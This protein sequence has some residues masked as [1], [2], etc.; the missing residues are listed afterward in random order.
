MAIKTPL[1]SLII[2]PKEILPKVKYAS[3]EA[4][5]ILIYFFAQPEK[6]LEEASSDLDLPLAQVQKSYSFWEKEG[7]FLEGATSKK[8]TTSDTSSYKNYDSSDISRML[9]ESNEFS[10]IN[11][12]ACE[13]LQ[14]PVLTKNDLSALLYLYDFAGIPAP[15]ICG[16]IEDCVSRDKKSMQYIR[17]TALELQKQGIDTYDKF[18]AY[19]IKR[20]EINSNIGRF[21][22]LCGMGE[23]ALTP[24]EQK[25]FDCW[26]GEWH[27]DFEMIEFAYEKTIASTG[28]LNFKYMNAI[29][30]NWYSSGYTS[31]QDVEN[32]EA[33]RKVG[34]ETSFDGD[35]FLEAALSRGFNDL[36]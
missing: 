28:K 15:L 27:F 10:M 24:R 9:K 26:F 11:A 32:G 22:K 31:V 1:D 25:Y 4:L 35:E 23:R 19:L 6:S 8:Q 7:I 5:Q 29:L 2:L 16:I 30:N 17:A 34:V 33:G 14:K 3:L 36:K 21:R 12:L 18:E 20:A 13:K